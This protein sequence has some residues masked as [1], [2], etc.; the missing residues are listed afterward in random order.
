[1]FAEEQDDEYGEYNAGNASDGSLDSAE[2]AEIFRKVNF[3]RERVSCRSDVRM[4]LLRA[5]RALSGRRD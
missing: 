2:E 5:P 3:N 4:S 1:M